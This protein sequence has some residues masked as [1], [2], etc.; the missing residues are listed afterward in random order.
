MVRAKETEVENLEPM[1]EA[2]PAPQEDPEL[3]EIEAARIDQPVSD[4]KEEAETPFEKLAAKASRLDPERIR[5]ILESLLFVTDKPLSVETLRNATGLEAAVVRTELTALRY[6]FGGDKTGIVLHEVA[7]GWQL[8]TAPE[9]SE[10][11]RRFLKVKPQRLT[12]AALETLAIVAYRQPVTR[13]EIEDVRA[14]DCG[15][16]LKALLERRLLK[17]IGKREEPGRPLL[18]GTS[19]EFLEF[20]NLRDLGS[21]PTLREFQELTEESRAIVEK[22]TGEA[23]PSIQA[24]AE[25]RTLELK[26]AET[27]EEV[28]AALVDLEAAMAQTDEKSAAVAEALKPKT[29]APDDESPAES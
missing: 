7:Q 5:A 8:R 12:R 14:V 26:L 16:V 20:F 28:D 24:L 18:Y 10:Y 11:V 1:P 4:E 17:I 25:E 21:L 13:P 22:T 3:D 23:P 29:D 2:A 9:N 15:A 27:A 19:K 6:K